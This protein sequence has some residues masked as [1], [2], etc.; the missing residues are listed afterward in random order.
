MVNFFGRVGIH[1]TDAG[2]FFSGNLNVGFAGSH[3]GN[4]PLLYNA[5]NFLIDGRKSDVRDQLRNNPGKCPREAK[6]Q[7][8]WGML[9]HGSP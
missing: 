4:T 9:A 5:R 1:I 3:E 8:R 2:R 6:C 7:M